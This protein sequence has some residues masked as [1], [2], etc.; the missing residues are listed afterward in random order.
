MSIP[1]PGTASRP[2][3]QNDDHLAGLASRY[4]EQNLDA[5]VGWEQVRQHLQTQHG[6]TSTEAARAL[7]LAVLD[8]EWT[9]AIQYDVDRFR[10]PGCRTTPSSR[11]C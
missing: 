3:S 6:K 7:L 10:R 9:G 2:R 5:T 1:Y 4:I 11:R 8:L